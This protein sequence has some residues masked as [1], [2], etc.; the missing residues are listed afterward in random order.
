MK[1]LLS[2]L[3]ALAM[4]LSLS[5]A[6]LAEVNPAAVQ[7]SD[8]CTVLVSATGNGFIRSTLDE[9]E[10]AFTHAHAVPGC[11]STVHSDIL[12]TGWVGGEAQQAWWR[13]WINWRADR[14][15]GIRAVTLTLNGADY[16]FSG[17]HTA[18]TLAE[19]NGVWSESACIVFG[20]ESRDFWMA[21]LSLGGSSAAYAEMTLP[22]VLHGTEDLACELNGAA[23]TDLRI[24]GETMLSL[25][26]F[27]AVSAAAGTEMAR[28]DI[29]AE[30]AAEVAEA[31]AEAE[32]AE[33]AEA[34]EPAEN[35]EAVEP[36][37]AAEAVEPEPEQAAEAVTETGGEEQ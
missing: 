5:G 29:A 23:L 16:T 24:M 8:R 20:A 11:P 3:L 1:K 21:F 22:M 26:G 15:L 7:G 2:L 28:A 33:T 34:V 12:V 19:E 37:V 31:V 25:A 18:D 6:A 32:P 27:D 13:L 9:A 10:T 4:L 36:A 17:L 30:E 35:A 14:P